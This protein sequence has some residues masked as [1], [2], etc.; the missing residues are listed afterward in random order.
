MIKAESTT[1]KKYEPARYSPQAS[2]FHFGSPKRASQIRLQTPPPSPKAP[3]IPLMP[4]FPKTPKRSSQSFRMPS[5]EVS[6]EPAKAELSPKPTG[7]TFNQLRG[8][9]SLPDLSLRPEKT[10]PETPQVPQREEESPAVTMTP[11]IPQSLDITNSD[12]TSPQVGV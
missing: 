4:S 2:P 10:K 11:H 1:D 3:T 5:P 8:S 9:Q 7:I 12:S 6:K